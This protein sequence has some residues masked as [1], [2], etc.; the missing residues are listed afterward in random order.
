MRASVLLC[1]CGCVGLCFCVSA[2]VLEFV[3]V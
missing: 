3:V 1:V 2:C